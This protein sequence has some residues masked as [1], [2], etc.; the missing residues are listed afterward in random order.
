M[1]KGAELPGLDVEAKFDEELIK[2]NAKLKADKKGQSYSNPIVR[3]K[4]FRKK[5]KRTRQ[6]RS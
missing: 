2:Q 4:L 5:K 1:P 3:F 6:R